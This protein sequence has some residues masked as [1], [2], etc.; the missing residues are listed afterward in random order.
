MSDILRLAVDGRYLNEKKV[1]PTTRRRRQQQSPGADLTH[2]CRPGRNARRSKSRPPGKKGQGQVRMIASASGLL[3]AALQLLALAR[4]HLLRGPYHCGLLAHAFQSVLRN[5][6]VQLGQ[7]TPRAA[8]RAAVD[9]EGENSHVSSLSLNGDL[10][11]A[12]QLIRPPPPMLLSKNMDR[13]WREW[14]SFYVK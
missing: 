11:T 6:A 5:A 13:N 12:Y 3:D 7:G 10:D 4:L 1:S 8:V 14:I 9:P 2:A